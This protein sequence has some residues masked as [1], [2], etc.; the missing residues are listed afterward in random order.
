M[1]KKL[2][3]VVLGVALAACMG[4]CGDESSMQL[5]Q[6]AYDNEILTTKP[7]EQDKTMITVRIEFGTGQDTILENMLE[8]KFPDVDIVLRHDGSAN[9]VYSL[10]EDLESGVECDFIMSRSLPAVSDIVDEYLLD[11]SGEEFVNNYYM[12]AADSCAASDGKL[13]YLP[14]P[15]DVYGIVY[16]K[17]LFEENGWE[18]P[19]SYSEFIELINTINNAGLKADDGVTDLVAFQPSIMFPDAFQI[20]FNTYGYQ[21]AYEGTDNYR[22]LTSYQG[23][24]G[25]M[26]GH[27]EG[28]VEKFKGLFED[29]VL[30]QSVLETQPRTRSLMLYVEHSAAM[31][32]ECENAVTYNESMA[33]EAGITDVHEMAMMPFWTSDEQD[34][35]FLYMIPSYYMA[36]NKASAEESS[37]KKEIL[38]E[39]FDFLSS[40]EGQELLLNGEFQ[41]SNIAGVPI[42]ENEF[43]EN[44][45]DTVERGQIISTFYL[46]EGETNKQ[47]ERQMLGTLGDMLYGNM[48]V[49]EWLEGADKTRD[50]YL[51]GNMTTAEEVYGTV[52]ET[53]TRLEAT[54]TVADMYR[55]L[56][57]ADIGIASGGGYRLSTNGYL[58]KGD[59]TDSLLSCV[60]P[61]KE[62]K[63]ELENDM[64][65]KICVASLTGQQI[66]DILNC[67]EGVAQSSG[68]YYYYVASGLDVTFNPWA[69]EGKRVVSCKLS[70]GSDIDTAATYTAAYFYGS[71]PEVGF[72]PESALSM[73][74]NESFIKWI[75]DIGG[76]I[77]KPEMSLKLVYE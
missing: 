40:V 63:A 38:L 55:E 49:T 31:T 1:R 42:V 59:I 20:F 19:H 14:G 77:K 64:D 4:G 75:G 30:S 13:Y 2:A 37:K 58:Y 70:D 73:T 10:R 23:G 74:W 25:S 32:M 48:S 39:I 29:G 61:N 62:P 65:E 27:M 3:A 33:E 16:D 56:T 34:S 15:S 44:I 7:V 51:A 9:S 43:S 68:E 67:S 54:Y 6:G 21:E 66:L 12:N 11:L 22:W 24:E 26:V 50:D 8:E 53:L 17:T 36:I 60:T 45:I 41:I 47:V 76:V 52:E 28:A 72:E 69:D 5:P 57:G 71:L 35:D 18:L 46:A